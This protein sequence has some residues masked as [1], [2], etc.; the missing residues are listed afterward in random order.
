MTDR[1][2]L[3]VESKECVLENLIESDKK[4]HSASATSRIRVGCV[5]LVRVPNGTIQS[6]AVSDQ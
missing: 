2:T 3:I 6:V 5:T 4:R 1:R